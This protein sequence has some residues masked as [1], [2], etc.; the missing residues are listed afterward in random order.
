MYRLGLLVT[1]GMLTASC[2]SAAPALPFTV[3]PGFSL[4]LVARIPAARDMAVAPNGDLFV[5]TLSNSVYVVPHAEGEPGTPHVFVALS[6]RPAHSVAFGPG[7]LYVGTQFGVWKV[8]YKPG[9][10]TA[11][12]APQRI[13][14]VRTSGTSRDHVTTSLAFSNGTLYAA[15]GSSCNVC[16]PELDATRASIQMM[17]PNGENMR[18]RAIHIRNAIALAVDPETGAVWAGVAGQD[19]LEKDHPY[20]IVDPFTLHSGVPDY[21]W[22]YCYENHRS[23]G[24]HDCAAQVV[25]RA[26]VPA[27][28]TPIGAAYY[29]AAQGGAHAFPQRWRGGLYLGLHGSW[30]RP[31]VP[32]RVVF[33]AMHGDVPVT[34]VDWSDPSK[35]WHEFVGGFQNADESRN[36]RATGIAVGPQGDLFVA[37][38]AGGAVYRVRPN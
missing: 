33:I 8:P 34:P 25:P 7:V 36:G 1:L 17:G 4:T 14:A 30:H 26:V 21:G 35:Q 10:E 15:V 9:E 28:I 31:L 16:D 37:D 20:E 13:A 6:D 29:P 38:D 18:P 5:G 24:T 27:Y 11:A 32:P 3:P 2:V 23:V 19:E 22:P 12:A